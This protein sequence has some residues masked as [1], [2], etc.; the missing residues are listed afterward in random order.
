MRQRLYISRSYDGGKV[1]DNTERKGRA[2]TNQEGTEEGG[3]ARIQQGKPEAIQIKRS[4]RG[5]DRRQ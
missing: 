4:Q 2:Y 1:G 3:S 5:K